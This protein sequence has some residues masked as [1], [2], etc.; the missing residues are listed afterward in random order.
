MSFDQYNGEPSSKLEKFKQNCSI[1]ILFENPFLAVSFHPNLYTIET[2]ESLRN[3][4][5][6]KIYNPKD[7]AQIFIQKLSVQSFFAEL[8]H[9]LDL[10]FIFQ[11]KL[12]SIYPT[13]QQS[14]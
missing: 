7:F 5:M 10:E 8:P 14:R 3:S 2:F 12:P 1:S 4:P 6:S 13:P 11:L 9:N